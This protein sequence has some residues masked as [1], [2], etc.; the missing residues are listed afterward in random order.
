MTPAAEDIKPIHMPSNS[1]VP[2]IASGFFGLAGFA[3]VFSWFW[4]AAIGGIGILA[5]LIYRS[6]DYDEGYYIS[7]DEIKKNRTYSMRGEMTWRL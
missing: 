3:L 7:V 5:C 4:L 6:F 1:G 2:I